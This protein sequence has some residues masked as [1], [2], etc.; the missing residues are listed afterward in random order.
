MTDKE[1]KCEDCGKIGDD[2]EV[3]ICPFAQEIHDEEIEVTICD[4]CY[5]ERCMDI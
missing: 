1:L 3:T 5:H 2:V 4:D